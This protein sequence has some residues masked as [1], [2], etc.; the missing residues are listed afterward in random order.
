MHDQIFCSNSKIDFG[1]SY[2]KIKQKIVFFPTASTKKVVLAVS[3]YHVGG[4]LRMFTIQLLF[5]SSRR[6]QAKINLACMAGVRRGRERGFW[7]QEKRGVCA[8]RER[9][10]N[11]F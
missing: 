5:V 1:D 3:I 6:N 2:L 9:E 7:A 11:M 10:G 4:G 8:R